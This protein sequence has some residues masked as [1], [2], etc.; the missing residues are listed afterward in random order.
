MVVQREME[1]TIQLKSLQEQLQREKQV[2]GEETLERDQIVQQ[3]K[4]TIQEVKLLTASEQKYLKK[5]IRAHE[6]SVRIQCSR[7]ESQLEKE[8]DLLQQQN[9][10]ELQAHE[11]IMEFLAY[12]RELLEQKIQD[13]MTKY[14]EDTEK[15]VQEMEALKQKRAAELEQYEEL[16][17]RHQELEKQVEEDKRQRQLAEEARKLEELR[18]QKATKIQRWWRKKREKLKA[19]KGKKKG[20]GSGKKGSGKKGSGKK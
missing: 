16:V 12:Q 7:K 20:K 18:N 19:G 17:G 6:N 10:I 5:E 8:K 4:D 11:S 13:W 15:K 2:L 9:A 1:S 14:E 3:L